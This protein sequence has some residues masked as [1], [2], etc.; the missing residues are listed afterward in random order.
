MNYSSDK[1][2]WEP[3]KNQINESQMTAFMNYVNENY[4]LSIE[5]YEELHTWSVKNIEKFWFSLWKFSNVIHS[6]KIAN[7]IDDQ[8]KMPGAKWFEG[9]QLNFAENLLKYKDDKTAIIFQGEGRKPQDWPG[10]RNEAEHWH[11]R[12]RIAFLPGQ[13]LHFR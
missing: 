3:T 9:V 10:C 1:I 4:Q 8:S 12:N 2:L 11:T 5:N 13:W 6:G 7:I